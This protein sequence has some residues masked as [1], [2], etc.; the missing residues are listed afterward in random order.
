M[1]C[2]P[3]EEQRKRQEAEQAAAPAVNQAPVEK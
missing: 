2:K 3:C 1:P